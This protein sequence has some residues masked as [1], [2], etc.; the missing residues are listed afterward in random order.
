MSSQ[1][2]N[3]DQIPSGQIRPQNTWGEFNN[4]SFAIQQAIGK[5]QTATLVRVESC[6]NSGGL[7]PVGFVDVTPLVNQL[8]GSGNPTPHVTI[9]NVPYLRV[10]GGA[11]GVIIDPQQGDVGVAVFA[12]R[13]ISKIK[14]TKKQ[15]NPGSF[16][17][18][19]FSDGMYL[20]GMLNGTPTQYVQF[21][22]S[23]ITIHSPEKITLS[24]PVIQMDASASITFTT[25]LFTVNGTMVVTGDVTAQGTSVHTHVHS[26]VTT[27]GSDTGVPV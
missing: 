10:Q 5:L 4:V 14:S 7:S 12:S 3:A 11:N 9:F 16:R 1:S 24:A 25:P 15:G 27:G 23:G 19:S 18:Y 17:Q 22:A 21:N 20:G 13:D 8:D 26:G 6:T 2:T